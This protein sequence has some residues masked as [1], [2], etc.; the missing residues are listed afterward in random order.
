MRTTATDDFRERLIWYFQRNG[1][2][3]RQDP[4][5]LAERGRQGYRKGD[6]VRLV[7]NSMVELREIRRMLRSAGFQPGRP[8]RKGRQYR[9]PVYGRAEVA[10]FLELLGTKS[11]A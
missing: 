6:E 2:V 7:A 3:R 1:Y 5:L 11:K 9:Q 10:R 4:E 8:F